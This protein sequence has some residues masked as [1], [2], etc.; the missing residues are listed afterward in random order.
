MV[1]VT[2]LAPEHFPLVAA[3]LSDRSV[4]RWLSTEWRLRDATSVMIAIACR[5]Q[6]NRLFLIRYDSHPC[7]LVGLAEIDEGD[8][9]AMVWYL[10][11]EADYAGKGVISEAVRQTAEWGFTELGLAS[12]YAWIMS[13]NERSRRVLERSGFREAGVLRM[14]SR[15]A[16]RQVDRIYFD[17]VNPRGES[18]VNGGRGETVA[19]H[20]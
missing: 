15:S 20:A 18:I 4:S 10:L 14:A 2:P 7:G 6:R 19:A 12:I 5:N 11:G 13:D 17:L 3:W 1:S 16:D 8:R 9:T